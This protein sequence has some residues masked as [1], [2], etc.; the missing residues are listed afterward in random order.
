MVHLAGWQKVAGYCGI[1]Y[2]FLFAVALFGFDANLEDG[3]GAKEWVDRAYD[4]NALRWFGAA[5]IPAVML[6]LWFA[7]GVRERLAWGM[8]WSPMRAIGWAAATGLT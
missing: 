2:F 8:G 3:L 7:A 5:A 4:G 6:W 1:G